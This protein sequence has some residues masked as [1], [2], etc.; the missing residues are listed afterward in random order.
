[1]PAAEGGFLVE[2]ERPLTSEGSSTR[3]H[4]P[5]APP[6]GRGSPSPGAAPRAAPAR[7][8]AGVIK[9]LTVDDQTIG[10]AGCAGRLEAPADI[11]GVGEWGD[12]RGAA[13]VA[14]R[15]RPG[16]VGVDIRRPGRVGIEAA[17]RILSLPGSEGVRVLVLTTFD[18]DEYVYEAF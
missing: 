9:V 16:V 5:E 2:A 18:V 13:R 6:G 8:A 15:N 3:G 11:T 17:R 14:G 7:G 4:G 1:G 12:G 10:W